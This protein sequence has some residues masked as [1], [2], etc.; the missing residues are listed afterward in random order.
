[1]VGLGL[2]AP[3]I[4]FCNGTPA[5]GDV[6]CVAILRPRTLQREVSHFSS[7]SAAISEPQKLERSVSRVAGDYSVI[8]EIWPYNE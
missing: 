4:P 2:F 1:M 3:F 7:L 8:I 5:G 6:A